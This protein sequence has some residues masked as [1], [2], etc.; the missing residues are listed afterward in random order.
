M[1]QHFIKSQDFT[2]FYS[3]ES[4]WHDFKRCPRALDQFGRI[5]LAF[6]GCSAFFDSKNVPNWFSAGATGASFARRTM[7]DFDEAESDCTETE[8]A[9]RHAEIIARRAGPC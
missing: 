6:F 5:S 1:I 7:A 8:V 3:F 9:A 4:Y 2:L